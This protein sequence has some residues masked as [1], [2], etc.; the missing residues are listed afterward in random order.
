MKPVFILYR[1]LFLLRAL[2][3]ELLRDNPQAG[4]EPATPELKVHAIYCC[5]VS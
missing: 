5:K 1:N 2:P 4:F 3:T